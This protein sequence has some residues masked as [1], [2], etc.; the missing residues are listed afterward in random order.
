MKVFLDMDGVLVDF[1]D[2]VH[3]AF[4]I[5]Y[6]TD[7][8]PYE[9]G[10]WNM[11]EDIK[12]PFCEGNFSFE[13]VNDLCTVGFWRGLNW[14][15][16]GHEILAAI[17]KKFTYSNEISLL[18]TPMPN[19]GSWTGKAYWVNKHIP[20]FNGR[21]IITQEPKKLFAGPDTLLIDDRDENIEEFEAAG[22]QGILV[23]RL[24]NKLH[25]WANN[26]LQVV[27]QSL[28]TL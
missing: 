27:E 18:T 10:K 25:N 28:E 3:R 13:T 17:V 22:G 8:H 21:L 2:G 20:T 24:W 4:N 9:K 1:L 11:L 5:P 26:T 12:R 16:D 15:H 6:S 14:M 19:F 23:P 7:T